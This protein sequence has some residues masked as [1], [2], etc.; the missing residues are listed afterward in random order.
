MI[1][2][3]Y[4]D[5]G[6]EAARG[7]VQ[8]LI[9]RNAPVEMQKISDYKTALQELVQRRRNQTLSY[10]LLEES[11][12]DHEKTFRVEV[13]LNGEAVGVGQ[14]S[15][16][17]RGRTVG[18][19]GRHPKAVSRRGLTLAR[20]EAPRLFRYFPRAGILSCNRTAELIQYQDR[21]HTGEVSPCT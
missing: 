8:R 9:L 11:G 19:G 2:A 6:F 17:K 7:I 4:L 1:A 10:Q 15:S 18:R 20:S 21:M 12:P 5:G 3:P 14:G 13:S 16:K